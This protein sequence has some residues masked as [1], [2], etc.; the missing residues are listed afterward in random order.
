LAALADSCCSPHLHRD[1]A[2]A[3]KIRPRQSL[4]GEEGGQ[5]RPPEGHLEPQEARNDAEE[6]VGNRSITQRRIEPLAERF[7]H[8]VTSK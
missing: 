2:A 1:G 6:A 7:I 8:A 3:R 4:E 5:S